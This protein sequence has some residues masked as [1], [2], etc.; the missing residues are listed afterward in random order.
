MQS[1]PQVQELGSGASWGC[2]TAPHPVNC[3]Q[4]G[5]GEPRLSS[6]GSRGGNPDC[7]WEPSGAGWAG[8][9]RGEATVPSTCP[10]QCFG[11][12][13]SASQTSRHLSPHIK[14][15]V[16]GSMWSFVPQKTAEWDRGQCPMTGAWRAGSAPTP[17][18]GRPPQHQLGLRGSGAEPASP[19]S[20]RPLGVSL[21]CRGQG[22]SRPP[23]GQLGLS[24]S[25]QPAGVR[26]RAGLP[27]VSSAC[28]GQLGLQGSGA[29]PTSLGV[30]SACGGQ[31]GL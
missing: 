8:M 13:C 29:E 15:G 20:A 31:L 6:L 5:Q 10:K 21:A 30:S 4:H 27:R 24:G 11:I 28:W 16:G 7:A 9:Q 17:R 12:N 25:T 26:G 22:Q 2:W 18:A 19:G 3:Q 23:Q 1:V 14:P